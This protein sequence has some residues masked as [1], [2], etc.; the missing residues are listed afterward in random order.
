MRDEDCGEELN[1]FLAINTN[2]LFDE[3]RFVLTNYR[4]SR[5]EIS[6][7]LNIRLTKYSRASI[8]EMQ[9]SDYFSDR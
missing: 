2:Y 6:L 8:T 7:G 9:P 4:I 5:W 1:R 3:T